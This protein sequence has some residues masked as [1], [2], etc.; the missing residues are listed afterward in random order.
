MN[1]T[2]ISPFVC[3]YRIL[4]GN[5]HLH[6]RMASAC[7]TWTA[8]LTVCLQ[9]SRPS[10]LWTVPAPLSQQRAAEVD[11]TSE[12]AWK[13]KDQWK[14]LKDAGASLFKLLKSQG[15]SAY[16]IVLIRYFLSFM[17]TQP[18]GTLRPRNIMAKNTCQW[19]NY[20]WKTFVWPRKRS[21][22]GL[23]YIK[24]SPRIGHFLVLQASLTKD[25]RSTKNNNEAF[26]HWIIQLVNGKV[27]QILAFKTGNSWKHPLLIPGI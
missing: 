2:S 19:E 27:C 5:S 20:A 24:M 26:W 21:E 23:R 14:M 18:L 11:K 16:S 13:M 17:M 15:T 6:Y 12:Q 8:A 1:H 9:L 3:W 10:L 22:R 7:T 25:C 4:L